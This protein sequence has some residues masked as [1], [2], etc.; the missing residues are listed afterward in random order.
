MTTKILSYKQLELTNALE[1]ARD[2]HVWAVVDVRVKNM[3]PQ[4]LQYASEVFWLQ[5]PEQ[6]KNLDVF[7]EAMD[8]FLKQGV[9]RGHTMLA[10]GGGATTDFA[11]FIASTLH[12]GV[13]WTAVPTTLMGMVDAAVGG[14]T[15]LNSRQGKNMMGSFHMPEEV[16]ICADFLRTLPSQDILSG[17][18]EIAKYALL[19]Q[20][21]YDLVMSKKSSLEDLALKCAHFK[22]S[23]VDRDP[24]EKGERVHLNLGHTIGHALEFVLKIPHGLAVVMGTKYLFQALQLPE[25]TAAYA[26]IIKQL[27]F[28]QEKIDL[29]NYPRFDRTAFWATMGHDKKRAN[30]ELNLVLI[31]GVGKPT[32]QKMTLIHLRQKLEK[33]D[34]FKG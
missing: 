17:K 16:W 3:L 4:W 14:K 33:L 25:A 18:G 24:T 8:F 21:I 12:R 22:Q 15:A 7:A 5:N 11:G 29:A 23:I 6:Q 34:V 28:D 9:Q 26:E 13:K 19:D 1:K 31:D 32:T 2:R 20:E 30:G 27:D 10:I